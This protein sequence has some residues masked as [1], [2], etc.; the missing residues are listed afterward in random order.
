MNVAWALKSSVSQDSFNASP[1]NPMKVI[2]FL[3]VGH[4]EHP[5]ELDVLVGAGIF[6]NRPPQSIAILS[7]SRYQALK[8]LLR[9]GF[10]F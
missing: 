10:D 9:L 7:E 5:I 8:P 2:D 4:A 1:A 3:L 6:S